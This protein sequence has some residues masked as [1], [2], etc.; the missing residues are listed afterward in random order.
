MNYKSIFTSLTLITVC[1]IALLVTILFWP[2]STGFDSEGRLDRRQFPQVEE[3]RQSWKLP[4]GAQVNIL[5]VA[6]NVLIETSETDTAELYVE[7]AAKQKA[8]LATMKLMVDYQAATPKAPAIL[9]LY[10]NEWLYQKIRPNFILRRLGVGQTPPFRER[11]VLKL[12]RQINL[13]VSD[14]SGDVTIGEVNGEVRILGT[15]GRVEIVRATRVRHLAG[16]RGSVEVTL[17]TLSHD[18]QVNSIGG[19][20]KLHFLQEPNARIKGDW[21]WGTLRAKLPG[22]RQTDKR[23]FRFQ[24]Q[25]GQGEKLILFSNILGSVTLDHVS[26][27]QLAKTPV[28]R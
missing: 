9:G 22:F 21:V 8:T 20:V 28:S 10:N 16:I 17:A 5:N 25:T 11:V 4:A 1:G 6:G 3:S 14:I 18:L 13:T 7:R 24:G 15:Q 27:P 2:R 23:F 12:P 26:Q 19:P